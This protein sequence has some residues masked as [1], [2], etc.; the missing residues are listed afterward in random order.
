MFSVT[1]LGFSILA[2]CSPLEFFFEITLCDRAH[3]GCLLP[4]IAF[5]GLDQSVHLSLGAKLGLDVGLSESGA[6]LKLAI[7]LLVGFL[8]LLVGLL[9]LLRLFLVLL[10]E[11]DVVFEGIDAR[12]VRLLES[13][14][15]LGN[16]CLLAMCQLKG[17]VTNRDLFLLPLDLLF[18]FLLDGRFLGRASFGS[19]LIGLGPWLPG[20]VLEG[21]DAAL[22]TQFAVGGDCVLVLFLVVFLVTNDVAGGGDF[23]T[24]ILLA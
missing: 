22:D 12:G 5:L 20:R 19:G 16:N 2:F 1:F 8:I 21:D 18:A 4:S 10:G 13:F 14:D 15:E 9:V 11:I 23:F 3:R 17:V 24:L 6:S 7:A